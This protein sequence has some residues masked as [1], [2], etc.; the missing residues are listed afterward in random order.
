MCVAP[1]EKCGRVPQVEK[2]R[3]APTAALT[4]GFLRKRAAQGRPFL[5]TFLRH[6][7]VCATFSA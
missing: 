5:R 2:H 4:L 3:A 6:Y 7:F 1:E